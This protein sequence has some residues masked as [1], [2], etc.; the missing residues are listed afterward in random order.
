MVSRGKR[1]SRSVRS[2][3]GPSASPPG[4]PGSSPAPCRSPERAPPVAEE[5]LARLRL[6]LA[7]GMVLPLAVVAFAAATGFD[8]PIAARVAYV[9]ASLVAL[10]LLAAARHT[11]A[12]AVAVAALA[13]ALIAELMH[14]GP[15]GLPAEA[16]LTAVGTAAA[17]VY[18]MKYVVRPSG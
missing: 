16:L 15:F 1:A 13:L 10:A 14:V 5:R 7:L 11:A 12:A 3:T 17:A 9:V 2:T 8:A 4:A 6:F 18:A